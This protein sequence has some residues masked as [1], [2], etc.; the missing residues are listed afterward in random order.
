MCWVAL[1]ITDEVINM[2]ALFQILFILLLM[3]DATYVPPT[4]EP[5]AEASD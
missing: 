1:A 2:M 4:P 3:G 5:P